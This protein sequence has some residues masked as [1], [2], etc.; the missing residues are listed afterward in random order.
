[1]RFFVPAQALGRRGSP[2]DPAAGH[3]TRLM[4]VGVGVF[5]LLESQKGAGSSRH[6]DDDLAG[7]RVPFCFDVAAG[8]GAAAPLTSACQAR[9]VQ[10]PTPAPVAERFGAALP[11]GHGCRCDWHSAIELRRN[12]KRWPTVRRGSL[13]LASAMSRGGAWCRFGGTS[14]SST[15]R[16]GSRAAA[17]RPPGWRCRACSPRRARCWR[18]PS[19]RCRRNLW[20]SSTP[21]SACG[22]SVCPGGVT[23]YAAPT[24]RDVPRGGVADLQRNRF[25]VAALSGRARP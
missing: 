7:L 20:P 17:P 23:S 13:S 19:V 8:R 5:S 1:M 15:S 10:C 12:S 16:S 25:A 6:P 2:V 14:T 4:W 21:F 11:R 18:S 3:G 22:Q 24:S 9:W